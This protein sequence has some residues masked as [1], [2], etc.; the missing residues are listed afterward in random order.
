MLYIWHISSFPFRRKDLIVCILVWWDSADIRT[1]DEFP[2]KV[3]DDWWGAMILT[4]CMSTVSIW[5]FA[6]VQVA[7][8]IFIEFDSY[9]LLTLGTLVS[10][11]Q[12]QPHPT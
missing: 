7:I 12:L 10:C 1:E 9:P 11:H 4:W 2:K 3:K 6:S 5:L 8:D